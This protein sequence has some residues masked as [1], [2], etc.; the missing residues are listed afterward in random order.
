MN[1]NPCFRLHYENFLTIEEKISPAG[2]FC[3]GTLVIKKAA[4]GT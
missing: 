1:K 3:N 2:Y 4:V